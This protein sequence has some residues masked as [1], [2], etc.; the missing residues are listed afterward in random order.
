MNATLSDEETSQATDA[1]LNAAEGQVKLARAYTTS[2]LSSA[3]SLD[4][5]YTSTLAAEPH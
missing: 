3:E 2:A 5:L 4:E 1:M